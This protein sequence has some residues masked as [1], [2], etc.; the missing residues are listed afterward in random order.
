MLSRIRL[1][2]LLFIPSDVQSPFAAWGFTENFF[3]GDPIKEFPL[4]YFETA[5]EILF[6][7]IIPG[8]DIFCHIL[9]L[10]T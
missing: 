8:T 6:N 3:V 2:V 9:P 10:S 1:A 7:W 4:R 5:F